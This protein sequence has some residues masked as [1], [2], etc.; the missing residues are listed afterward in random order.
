MCSAFAHGFEID[1]DRTVLIPR[2]QR[3]YAIANSSE[4]R[5]ELGSICA[6]QF[7]GCEKCDADFRRRA[8][9]FERQPLHVATFEAL[10]FEC[11]DQQID[12]LA[13]IEQIASEFEFVTRRDLPIGHANHKW[14]RSITQPTGTFYPRWREQPIIGGAVEMAQSFSKSTAQKIRIYRDA[15]PGS[16]VEPQWDYFEG[17]RHSNRS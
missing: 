15:A 8:G 3:T 1:V 11:A 17:L 2:S 12:G 10:C 16:D 13:R 4:E 14:T 5:A 6:L 9:R 7:G